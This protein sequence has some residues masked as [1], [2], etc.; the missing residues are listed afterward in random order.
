MVRIKIC[1]ITRPQ[2]AVAAAEAGADAIG[3]VFAK[4][5]RQ[6]TI[7]Q[8]RAIVAALPPF[9]SAVGVF[10]NVRPATVLR[11]VAVVGLSEVQLHGDESPDYLHRL[12]TIRSADRIV[13][14][15]GSRIVEQGTHEELMAKGG[16]YRRLNEVQVEDGARWRA[17]REARQQAAA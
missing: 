8:A 2:D 15:E 12:S 11:A 13:V 4:S 17:L 9:V 16:L 14:L 10:A 3:V 1:G 5:P 7:R 6:V